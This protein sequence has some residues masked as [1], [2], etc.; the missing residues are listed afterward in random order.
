MADVLE[1]ML[2]AASWT[3]LTAAIARRITETK[4][5]DD[6]LDRLNSAIKAYLTSL[7]HEAIDR[8]DDRRYRRSWPSSPTLNMRAISSNGAWEQPGQSGQTGNPRLLT[9]GSR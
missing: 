6:V 8:E 1:T 2:R 5:L 3:G 9:R 4:R 7:D